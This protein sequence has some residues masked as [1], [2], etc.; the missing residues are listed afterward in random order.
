MAFDAIND[1]YVCR[2]CRTATRRHPGMSALDWCADHELPG[3]P[4]RGRPR[5]EVPQW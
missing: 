3:G 1:S 2:A 4:R 5:R